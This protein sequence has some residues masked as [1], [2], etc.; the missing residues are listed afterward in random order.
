MRLVAILWVTLLVGCAFVAGYRI[1]H[2]T[3]PV[4]AAP[5]TGQYTGPLFE[6]PIGHKLDAPSSSTFDPDA[7][8]GWPST[9]T[10]SARSTT[11]NSFQPAVASALNER[12]KPALLFAEPW[13]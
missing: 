4:A 1:G 7:F 13:C 10:G 11:R 12:S 8:N 6:P 9:G 3:Q 2:N 5:H